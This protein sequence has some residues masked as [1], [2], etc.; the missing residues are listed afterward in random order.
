MCRSLLRAA[1]GIGGLALLA[2]GCW[3]TSASSRAETDCVAEGAVAEAYRRGARATPATYDAHAQL[4]TDPDAATRVKGCILLHLVSRYDS[5]NGGLPATLQSLVPQVDVDSQRISATEW[6]EDGWRRP[7][8]WSVVATG[9]K[10]SSRGPDGLEG[11]ADD[12]AFPA[13]QAE[14]AVP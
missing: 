8:M 3:P 13:V 6:Y 2:A 9:A 11:T 12:I 1:P 7:F 5:I 14:K 4:D 10:L